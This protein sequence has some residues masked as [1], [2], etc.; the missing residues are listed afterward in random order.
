MNN[1]IMTYA[2]SRCH[3]NHLKY[4]MSFSNNIKMGNAKNFALSED[5]SKTFS[6]RLLESVKVRIINKPC[7]ASLRQ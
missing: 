2:D 1:V 6:Q 3:I 4:A 5:C 7:P